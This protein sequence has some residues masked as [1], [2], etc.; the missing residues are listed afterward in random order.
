MRLT[1]ETTNQPNAMSISTIKVFQ[2]NGD[3]NM[4]KQS[5]M[6]TI[7]GVFQIAS[8]LLGL[9]ILAAVVKEFLILNLHQHPAVTGGLLA[10]FALS[11]L[12]GSKERRDALNHFVNQALNLEQLLMDDPEEEHIMKQRDEKLGEVGSMDLWQ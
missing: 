7:K 3:D 10:L 12:L 2:N 1:K 11:I 4:N 8:G 6:T 9:L 5:M